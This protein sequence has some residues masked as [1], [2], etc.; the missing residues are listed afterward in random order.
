MVDNIIAAGSSTFTDSQ[1][2]VQAFKE[3]RKQTLQHIPQDLAWLLS[4]GEG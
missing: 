3:A 1:I 4:L 2:M